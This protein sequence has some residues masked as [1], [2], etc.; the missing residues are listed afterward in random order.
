MDTFLHDKCDENGNV[1]LQVNSEIRGSFKMDNLF[2]EGAYEVLNYFKN[3]GDIFLLSG[4]NDKTKSIL[5][6]TFEDES[7]L[8]YRQSPKDKLAFV[9][10]QQEAGYQIG[11]LGDGLNDAGAL[12]Q[13]DLGIV[14]AENTNN[15]TPACDAIIAAEE[16]KNLPTFVDF[17]KG[18]LRLVYWAYAFALVYNIIGLSFAV[19]GELSPIVAAILM[20]LS[21]IS[22]VAFGTLSSNILAR[23][24]GL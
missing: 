10:Q 5:A 18:S 14:V 17:A 2:R 7:H 6:P 24:K 8:M 13:S 1:F 11:M 20:P 3:R 9:K 16:F 12:Q 4:D 15:F 23:K 22:I 19:Q 21:S